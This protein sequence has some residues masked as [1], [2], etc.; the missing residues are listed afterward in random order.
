MSILRQFGR[1]DLMPTLIASLFIAGCGGGGDSPSAQAATSSTT[2]ASSTIAAVTTAAS[3]SGT[4]TVAATTPAAVT[5]TAATISGTNLIVNPNFSQGVTGWSLYWSAI[6]PSELRSGG[7]ALRLNGTASQPLSSSTILPHHSYEMA[8]TGRNA[9]GTGSAV[10]AV[11]FRLPNSTTTFRTFSRAITP[12]PSATYVIDF[13]APE[14]T[15]N[16]DFSVVC[17]YAGGVLIDTVSVKEIDP[18]SQTEPITSPDNSYAPAGYTLKFNDE[19]NGTAL[20][21]SKWFTRYIYGSETTDHLNDEKERYRDNGNH[22]VANGVLS[23]VAKKVAD[24]ADGVNYESGMIRSDWTA[25][26]GYFAARV[27]MPKGVGVWPAFWL[28]SDVSAVGR[29]GWPPEIDIF[30]YVN[31]GVE[32]KPNMFHSAMSGGA[33][34]TL[35]WASPNF[36]TSMQE[37]IGT[38]NFDEDW[39]IFGCLWDESSVTVYLDGNKVYTRNFAWNYADG[40]LAGPAHIL[41]NLAIGGAWAGRHGIDDGAFP[42][43]LQIDWVRAYQKG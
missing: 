39:H 16:V 2:S 18:I 10:V 37:Y 34:S 28:N 15:G 1:A 24:A 41:L 8:V 27:K 23:L 22:V 4:T 13:T 40:T 43:A 11:T 33:L 32:D 21:R 30:E 12:G 3:T 19:F 26:Y 36:N 31:N 9:T 17:G 42:Q 7:S 14:Y 20:N 38:T 6:V 5:A 35:Q 25:R 29:M